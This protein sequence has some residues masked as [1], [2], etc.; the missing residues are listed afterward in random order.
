MPAAGCDDRGLL[1]TCAAGWQ[2]KQAGPL[3]ERPGR[4]TLVF[5]AC[6]AQFKVQAI[7]E[8]GHSMTALTSLSARRFFGRRRRRR[9][10][11]RW[12]W[13]L[14]DHFSAVATTAA[15]ASAATM[16]TALVPMTAALLA[17][18]IIGATAAI[19]HATAVLHLLAGGFTTAVLLHFAARF[20]AVVIARGMARRAATMMAAAAATPSVGLRLQA[21]EHDTQ[22]RQTQGQAKQISIHQSTS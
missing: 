21:N 22:R 6:H 10:A 14:V 5:A 2:T 19:T 9:L 18:I 15:I 8:S 7:K 11:V 3:C 16:T 4:L 12:S 20:M 1:A 13:T 17:T